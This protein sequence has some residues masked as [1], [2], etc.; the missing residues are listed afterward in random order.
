MTPARD[1]FDK[2]RYKIY[3][4]KDRISVVRKGKPVP[5]QARGA[6]RVPGS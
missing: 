5:L 6:Q 4:N 1:A 3:A 2:L